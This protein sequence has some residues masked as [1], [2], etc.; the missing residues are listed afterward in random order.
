MV[1][2]LY[3]I[4]TEPRTG[5]SAIALGLTQM[6]L[7]DVQRVAFFRPII[8]GGQANKKDHDINLI[9]SQFY[10]NQRYE[11]TYAFTLAEARDII[12]RGEHALLV[13][14]I[15]N[16]YK[17]L[18]Q[19]FDFVL[20]EG[21]DFLGSDPAFE[22]DINAEIAANLG[23]PVL[24][25]TNA[26]G[27]SPDEVVSSTQLAIDG[28]EEKGLDILATIINRAE[29][30]DKD[31][32]LSQ[33][34][35]KFR[36]TTECLHYVIPEEPSLG[37]PTI[38]DVAKWLDAEVLY[39][40]GLLDAQIDDY[41]VAAMQVGNFLDYISKNCL[42]ITPG[43]RSDIILSCYASRQSTEYPDMAGIVLTGGIE[44]QRNIQKIIEGWSGNPMPVL[45]TKG[46]TFKTA[47]VLMDLYGRI[48][49]E[50]QKKIAT[51]LGTFE[52][53]VDVN[54]L[55]TRLEAK[56]STR[57]TPKMFEYSLIEK[58]KSDRKHIVLPEGSSGR[59]LKA[60]DI[61]LRRGVVD[62]T[63]LGD[64]DQI[65]S[66][67]SQ[68]G[69]D[70]SAAQIICPSKSE[71]FDAYVNT[72][73]EMRKAKGMTPEVARDTMADP[74][75][76]GTMMVKLGH[77][78]GMV[79]GSITTTAQTIRPA[80]QIIK[81]KP[82][83]SIVSSV[84]LMCLSDRVLVFG[85][86]AVIPNPNAKELADIAIQSSETA[87]IFGVE[88]RVAM[89][90]Y[91]TGESGS[92]EDVDK[93]RE[94]TKLVRELQPELL[95]EGPLQYDAAI[96]PTVAATKMPGS[97]VA[98]KATVF[99]FPDLNTGNNTYKAVQRAAGAVAIGP[100][101]QGLNAPV[102]DLSRGCTVEDIVNTVAITAIQAQAAQAQGK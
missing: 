30:K 11:D 7:R 63:I 40:K 39:G 92:G 82:G 22:V 79:S 98:G 17:S 29:V 31:Y 81:T 41:L 50:D 32:V 16:K 78:H 99:I 25:V 94:A 4:G 42:V 44:P 59:I 51:A 43:D 2:N 71:Q 65:R 77:A 24:L 91:S 62:L 93:V 3:I 100:V 49:A 88:P 80:F 18:E 57:V 55:R 67:I 69:L 20:C 89:L 48:D 37:K 13:E 52:T 47:R 70:L 86:C 27:K 96:D 8:S 87:R 45:L 90:S 23:A 34:S 12:N 58:A 10:L 15:L 85:D 35:C 95:V 68:M 83:S 26:Q 14:T 38:N 1:K 74:T 36:S 28:F 33:L 76:F 66:D 101:L 46:H 97:A 61:L 75:Y 53:H 84:F 19:R 64:P 102:N 21:T 54:E 6:L 56:K 72:F 60:A 9:L 5:K 73:F